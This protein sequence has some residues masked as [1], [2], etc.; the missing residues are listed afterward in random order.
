MKKIKKIII[1]LTTSTMMGLMGTSLLVFSK[2]EFSPTITHINN[3]SPKVPPKTI[4]EWNS[5]TPENLNSLPVLDTRQVEGMKLDIRNQGSHPN[6]WAWS[7]VTAMAMNA[8]LT[9]LNKGKPLLFDGLKFSQTI[10]NKTVADDVLHLNDGG[11]T[12]WRHYSGN[13]PRIITQTLSQNRSFPLENQ[14]EDKV[15]FKFNYAEYLSVK[16]KENIKQMIAKYGAVTGAY[17]TKNVEG[18]KNPYYHWKPIDGSY[19]AA[20]HAITIVGWDDTIPKEKFWPMTPEHD[21]GMNYSKLM[22]RI[23]WR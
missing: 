10:T 5:L 4:A 2:Y 19:P 18:G 13:A 16:T 6:C 14:P 9:G 11:D 3:I 20:D 12:W 17:M 7:I 8:Q 21:G 22:G 15:P 23:F 1:S